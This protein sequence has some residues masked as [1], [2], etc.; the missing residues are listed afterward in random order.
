[1]MKMVGGVKGKDVLEKK[2]IRA[3]ILAVS[4]RVYRPYSQMKTA[5]KLKVHF[6]NMEEACRFVVDVIVS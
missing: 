4:K 2:Q 5:K 6:F 1:M 3:L